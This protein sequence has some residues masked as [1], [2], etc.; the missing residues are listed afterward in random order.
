M[1]SVIPVP[2][3]GFASIMP[4][5]NVMAKLVITSNTEKRIRVKGVRLSRMGGF[6]KSTDFGY[7][8][9]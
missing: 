1:M 7:F 6:W 5:K 4:N 2:K 8:C 9:G 3:R